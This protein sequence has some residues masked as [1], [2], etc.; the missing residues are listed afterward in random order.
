MTLVHIC[1]WDAL[2]SRGSPKYH[3]NVWNMAPSTKKMIKGNSQVFFG[4]S[5][6]QVEA[7]NKESLVRL[8]SIR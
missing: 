5:G 3:D 2:T 4:L 8:Y 6:S 1:G 7:Q